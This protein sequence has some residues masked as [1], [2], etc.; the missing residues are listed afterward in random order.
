MAAPITIERF[1]QQLEKFH[2]ERTDGDFKP[3]EYDQ[4]IAR[5]L[6]ELRERGIDGDRAAITAA[7][8]DVHER[9]IITDSV[10][11]HLR[12]RLGLE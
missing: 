6:Q 4:R 5:M 1:V 11:D 8:D 12:K 3:A 10:K 7:L 9:G 2:G